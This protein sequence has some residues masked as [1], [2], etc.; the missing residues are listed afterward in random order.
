MLVLLNSSPTMAVLSRTRMGNTSKNIPVF[1]FTV[2]LAI[3]SPGTSSIS[4]AVIAS[5]M[6]SINDSIKLCARGSSII[7]LSITCGTTTCNSA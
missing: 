4:P 7:S 6:M 2:L 5:M 1:T 3:I